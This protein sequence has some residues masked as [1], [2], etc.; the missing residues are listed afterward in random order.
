[1]GQA[2][3]RVFP[4][5]KNIFPSNKKISLSNKK[6]FHTVNKSV[7]SWTHKTGKKRLQAQKPIFLGLESEKYEK[8]IPFLFFE[9]YLK[10]AHEFSVQNG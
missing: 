3:A 2:P 5:N 10:F 9:K 7:N 4:S 1:L 8:Q 6:I